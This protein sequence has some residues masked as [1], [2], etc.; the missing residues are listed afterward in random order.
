MSNYPEGVTGLEYEIAGPDLERDGVHEDYC[1]NDDC[2]L[3][4]QYLEQ[5]GEETW[6][7]GQGWFRW[8]CEVCN[9]SQDM[10]L[11]EYEEYGL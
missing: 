2:P 4:E 6:Y 11:P 10:E 7:R 8:T 1:R 3:F 9:M 5:D